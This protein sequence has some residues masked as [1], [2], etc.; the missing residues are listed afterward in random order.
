MTLQTQVG[1]GP[2]NVLC[3]SMHSS[4]DE[5]AWPGAAVGQWALGREPA[6]AAFSIVNYSLSALALGNVCHWS[7]AAAHVQIGKSFS[8]FSL[9]T[10]ENIIPVTSRESFL[11]KLHCVSCHF[12]CCAV[13]Q[14]LGSTNQLPNSCFGGGMGSFS[15]AL[16]PAQTRTRICCNS[17]KTE[18]KGPSEGYCPSCS[19]LPILGYYFWKPC[20]LEACI[21]QGIMPKQK[22]FHAGIILGAAGIQQVLM[23][24]APSL[25]Q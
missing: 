24:V 9:E 6:A 11:V 3:C 20:F 19:V 10:Q 16:H 17:H 14:F 8:N 1:A 18:L 25:L 21:A 4:R 12:Q 7:G 15:T 13:F 2:W 23:L 22:S 5:Q